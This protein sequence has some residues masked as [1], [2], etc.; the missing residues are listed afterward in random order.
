VVIGGGAF[1][2]MRLRGSGGGS[3]P[4]AA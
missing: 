4:A 3:E 2:A 1:A